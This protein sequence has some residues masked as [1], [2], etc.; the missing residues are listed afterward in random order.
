MKNERILNIKRKKG[1]RRNKKKDKKIYQFP[2]VHS[3]N[4]QV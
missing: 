1:I 2:K 4:L 3:K